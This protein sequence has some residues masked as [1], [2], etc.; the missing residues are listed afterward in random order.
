MLWK[1]IERV[2]HED[3]LS[4]VAM[5]ANKPATEWG[6]VYRMFLAMTVL[7]ATISSLR[8]YAN[9]T[10]FSGHTEMASALVD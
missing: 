8:V 10:P 4:H 3:S 6:C 5:G 7:G 1:W 2:S 9:G